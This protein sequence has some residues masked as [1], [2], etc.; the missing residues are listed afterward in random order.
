MIK[1]KFT[2][3]LKLFAI[4]ICLLFLSASFIPERVFAEGNSYLRVLKQNTFL[5]ADTECNRAVFT[6]PYGY[7]VKIREYTHPYAHVECYYG[8][9]LTA[10]LDGYVKTDELTAC[11]D[12][13]TIPYLKLTVTLKNS[14]VLY[15]DPLKQTVLRNVFSSRTLTYFGIYAEEPNETMYFVRYGDTF[16]YMD[17]QAFYPFTVPDNPDPLPSAEDP[18]P[19]NEEPKEKSTSKG[20]RI[21]VI[22]IMS[23]AF[24]LI[25]LSIFI[26]PKKKKQYAETEE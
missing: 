21:A 14:S 23:V 16:G 19:P 26:H 25:V 6:L 9:G 18:N 15:A 13:P 20:L 4:I 24:V 11:E 12:E 10:L 2:V 5:Y 7:Y 3:Y 22:V 17:A 8:E 1:Y